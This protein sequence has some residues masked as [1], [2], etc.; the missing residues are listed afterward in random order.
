MKTVAVVTATTGR[1]SLQQTM[2]SVAAQTYP[3]NHYVIL[4]G[5][6]LSE[7]A[8]YTKPENCTILKLPRLGVRSFVLQS[9]S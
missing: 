3:C 8:S 1:A 2:D 9:E 5:P 7:F 6:G 4:D